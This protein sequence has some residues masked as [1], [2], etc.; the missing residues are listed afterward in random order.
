L[1]LVSIIVTTHNSGRTLEACLTSARRQ[2]YGLVELIIVD[3]ESSD[4]TLRIAAIFADR[5]LQAGPER[6]AQRN[7]GMKAAYVE[8]IL[9]L[10][11][12][13]VLDSNV[14]SAALAASAGGRRAV[15]V[16]EISFGEGF[17]S[18]C[19]TFERSFYQ[20]DPIVSAA[21]FF[22]RDVA[23]EIGGYDEELVA[24][25]DW[26]ISMRIGARLPLAFA[27]AIIH[28]D[29]GR[30]SLLSLFAK[31]R[32]YGKWLPM[33][34]HKHG[35]EA[36]R[37]INPVRRSLFQGVGRLMRRP[38]LGLGV[39]LVK[40]VEM[41]GGLWGALNRSGERPAPYKAAPAV[42]ES[43]DERIESQAGPHR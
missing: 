4:D 34:V 39:V 3:N 35:R 12:D 24:F 23:L 26:D 42:T 8:Y 25:E 19:K 32:Y 16:P 22:P 43:Y 11:A 41:T 31:K 30:Q 40:A 10:D 9:V 15:V 33:F 38:V 37:R 6:C 29:E 5:V 17:W 21:R 18:A 20:S 28:H 36:F 13:M 2:D 27:N 14:V 7:A 1:E